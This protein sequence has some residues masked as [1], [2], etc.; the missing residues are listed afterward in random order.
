MN[1]AHRKL[2]SSAKWAADIESTVVPWGLSDVELGDDVLEIGPGFGAAT[3]AL[4]QRPIRLTAIEIDA[5]SAARLRTEFAGRAEIVHGDGTALPFPDAA[6]DAV[7]CF[8]MLHHVPTA[9]GQDRL[10]AEVVRVLRPGGVFAGTDSRA[11]TR[12]RLFH[13]G[14]TYVP[15]DHETLPTRLRQAGLHDVHVDAADNR[16]R[17]RGV[18][19]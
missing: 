17:F 5:A 2:C 15:L 7:V 16:I 1:L 19:A 6:Y 13:V 18:R 3:R 10:F 12:L 14:D 11:S 9:G 4:V 8:T